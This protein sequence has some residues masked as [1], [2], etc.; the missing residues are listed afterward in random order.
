MTYLL[1]S[2]RKEKFKNWYVFLE[3]CILIRIGKYLGYK[4]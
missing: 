3:S 2:M 1:A 4:N